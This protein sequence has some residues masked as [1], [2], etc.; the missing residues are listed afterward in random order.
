[1][2]PDVPQGGSEMLDTL[3]FRLLVAFGTGVRRREALPYV[4]PADLAMST[5]SRVFMQMLCRYL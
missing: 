3:P 2:L 5:G 1:M 4:A